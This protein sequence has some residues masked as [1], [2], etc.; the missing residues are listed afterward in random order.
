MAVVGDR[1]AQAGAVAVRH[2]RGG[3][4]GVMTVQAFAERVSQETTTRAVGA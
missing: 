1:E 2:R 4:L 3:D